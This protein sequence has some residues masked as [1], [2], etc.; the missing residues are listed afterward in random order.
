MAL[1]N[2]IFLCI[3]CFVVSAN[4]ARA[5][6]TTKQPE[7]VKPLF[8][9]PT[10]SVEIKTDSTK[11]IPAKG[12]ASKKDSARVFK[13]DPRKATLRSAIIPGWGQAYNREYWKI[14]IVYG[15]LAVPVSLYIYNNNYYKKTKFAYQAVYAAT[16]Q[17]PV[18]KSLL[19]KIDPKVLDQLT[20]QPLNLATYQSY[21]NSFKRDKDYSLLWIFIVWGL[22]VADATVF[23]HLKDFDVSDDL[24]MQIQPM[25]IPEIKSSGI[26]LV[27]NLRQPVHKMLPLPT[28]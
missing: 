9:A 23:G 1:L 27:F 7:P 3:I 26:G 17:T 12:T 25:F 24:S 16:M 5:Q 15:A 6:D 14:P 19:L 11:V 8:N 20:G 28:Q 18:D 21:R 10:N 13:H 2:K 22:N 4:A